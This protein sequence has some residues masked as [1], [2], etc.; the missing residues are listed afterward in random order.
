[1]V[2]KQECLDN[3]EIAVFGSS[4]CKEKHKRHVIYLGQVEHLTHERYSPA[5][6][7]FLIWRGTLE[8]CLSSALPKYVCSC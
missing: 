4:H 7:L 6:L 1:M 3:S 8:T 5:V 2:R